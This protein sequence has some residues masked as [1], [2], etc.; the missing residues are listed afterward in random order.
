VVLCYSPLGGGVVANAP[1]PRRDSRNQML[2]RLSDAALH[3]LEFPFARVDH[4]L[5]ADSLRS[6]TGAVMTSVATYAASTHQ[7]TVEGISANPRAIK[8]LTELIGN[9]LPG[10]SFTVDDTALKGHLARELVR[11]DGLYDLSFGAFP[12]PL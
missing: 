7:L 3:F 8:S 10:L 2:S 4:Q 12:R 6:L 1:G 9:S 5:I 11:I